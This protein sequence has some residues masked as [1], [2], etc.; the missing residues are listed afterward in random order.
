[1]TIVRGVLFVRGVMLVHAEENKQ[2]NKV[3][4]T[5]KQCFK[6]YLF[7]FVAC[8]VHGLMQR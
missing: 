3:Q 5:S 2:C 6:T 7:V 4:F 1:M 8:I